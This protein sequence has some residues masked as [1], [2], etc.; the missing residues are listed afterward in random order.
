MLDDVFGRL[1]GEE[2][3]TFPVMSGG[4]LVGLLTLENLGEF[5]RIQAALSAGRRAPALRAP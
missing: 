1:Q 4:R 5:L 3:R 2:S